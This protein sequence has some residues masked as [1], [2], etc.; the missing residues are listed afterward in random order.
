MCSRA[1]I[2]S[3]ANMHAPS[4]ITN[5]GTGTYRQAS[6]WNQEKKAN[7]RSPKPEAKG[8]MYRRKIRR[9]DVC[10]VQTACCLFVMLHF[11]KNSAVA[12]MGDRLACHI[13]WGESVLRGM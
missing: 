13:T 7:K 6:H 11:N 10:T 2:R 4:L 3:D 1:G 5:I 9:S 8:P 12:E